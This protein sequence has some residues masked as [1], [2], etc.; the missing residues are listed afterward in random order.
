MMVVLTRRA[1]AKTWKKWTEVEEVEKQ[2]PK[3]S[4][5]AFGNRIRV[6]NLTKLL[7]HSASIA[8][9]NPW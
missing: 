4:E 3:I 2:Q 9:K 8:R 1:S 7:T 5:G 6:V